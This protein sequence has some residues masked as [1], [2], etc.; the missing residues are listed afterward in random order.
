MA[1]LVLAVLFAAT[2]AALYLGMIAEE[3]NRGRDE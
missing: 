2:T 3:K 1:V